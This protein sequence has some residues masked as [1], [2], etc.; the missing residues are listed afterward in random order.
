MQDKRAT[1]PRDKEIDE[2]LATQAVTLLAKR[3]KR[4]SSRP[5]S[6]SSVVEKREPVPFNIEDL[7][8]AIENAVQK[9]TREIVGSYCLSAGAGAFP[10]LPPQAPL[11]E[12]YAV[13]SSHCRPFHGLCD[14]HSGPVGGQQQF[15]G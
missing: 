4:K 14:P 13:S 11:I 2:Y 6:P 8:K 7:A 10:G 15:G 12:S 1:A 5:R 9:T 3:R